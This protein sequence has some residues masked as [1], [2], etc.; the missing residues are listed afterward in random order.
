MVSSTGL[1][2]RLRLA[3][4]DNPQALVNEG[5]NLYSGAGARQPNAGEVTARIGSIEKSNVQPVLEI[6]RMIEISRAYSSVA[7]MIQRT[8]DCAAPPSS[9]LPIS[10]PDSRLFPRRLPA[11]PV[12]LPRVS[13]SPSRRLGPTTQD[14][15][16]ARLYTAATGMMAQE[17]NVEVISNNVANLRTTGFKRQRGPFPG[18]DVRAA[19]P[20]RR[21]ELRAEHANS[22]RRLRRLWRQDRLNPRLMAQGN[23]DANGE[24]I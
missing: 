10:R 9:D 17:L 6:A 21:A 20:P 14:E 7:Q 1:R 11:G 8:D 2:G 24:G 5:Q 22:R 3:V 18:P 23:L 16:H 4:F 19:A 12:F 15:D 13:I